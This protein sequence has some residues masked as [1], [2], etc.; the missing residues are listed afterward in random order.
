MGGHGG[1]GRDHQIR[2]EL[3]GGFRVR[4]DRHSTAAMCRSGE[5][6]ACAYSP[7]IPCVITSKNCRI[8]EVITQRG[9]IYASAMDSVELSVMLR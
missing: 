5:P 1:R 2:K 6:G 9:G 3:S 7:P 4:L 8:F